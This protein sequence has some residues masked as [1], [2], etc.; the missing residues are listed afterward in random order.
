MVDTVWLANIFW[1]WF[2]PAK[3]APGTTTE[4]TIKIAEKH[5][6]LTTSF[7]K[8]YRYRYNQQEDKKKYARR[9]LLIQVM[10]GGGGSGG[11]V[12]NFFNAILKGVMLFWSFQARAK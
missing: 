4:L 8:L 2:G 3:L 12:K 9:I 10:P 7:N 1:G 6:N 5:E 11:F